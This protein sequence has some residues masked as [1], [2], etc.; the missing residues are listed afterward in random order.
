[1]LICAACGFHPVFD[2]D[3]FR[4]VEIPVGLGPEWFNDNGDVLV[5]IG[6]FIKT[7]FNSRGQ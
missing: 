3:F 4:L 2:P 7:A 5:M 6:P 1:V